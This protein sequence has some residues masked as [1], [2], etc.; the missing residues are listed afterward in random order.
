MPDLIY[1]ILKKNFG[2]DEFRTGQKEIIESVLAGNDNF[3]LMPT[4]SGKS[5]CYQLP[6][7]MLSGLTLV[8]SP[9]IALMKDQVDSL[10]ANGVKAAFINS[11]LPHNEILPVQEEALSGKLKI[12]Y[13]APERMALDN[14]KD[15]LQNL[16]ISLIAVDEAHCISEWGHD[17]R[18]DY[19]NLKMLKNI[20]RKAPIIALTATAT[21]KVRLDI[22]K[23]L[24][25]SQA[26]I[27]ISGF[28]RPNLN[29]R[30]I[31]KKNAFD[32]LLSL[33]K[34]Y[35]NKAVIIYCFSRKETE[36]LAMDLK[37]TGFKA[38]AY[39][40][41]MVA[42]ERK[43]TQELFIRDEFNII[44]ATIAFGM[45]IDK[46][47]VRLVVHY[48]FPKS[49]EGYYQEI[50][51]AGRDGLKSDCVMF[52]T[53]ADARKHE[54][55]LNDIADETIRKQTENKLIEV[56]KFAELKSCRRKHILNYFGENYKEANCHGCDN[57]NTEKVTLDAT[58]VAQKILSAI[59]RTGNRF[60]ANHIINILKGK[61]NEKIINYGH[62]KLSVYDIVKDYSVDELKEIINLI[63]N[64]G[65][66][67]KT[68]D[69]Y[70]VLKVT[71]AGLKFISQKEKLELSLPSKEDIDEEQESIN[72]LTYDKTLFEKLRYLR[73]QI[74]DK[75]NVP[76]FVIFSDASLQEMAFYFPIDKENFSM[77]TGVGARKLESFGNDFLKIIIAYVK[78]NNLSSKKIYKSRSGKI[79]LPREERSVN[80]DTF[81]ITNE[82]INR[83][84]SIDDMAKARGLAIS[85]IISHIEQLIN[86]GEK[87]D[88]E[89]LKPSPEVYEKIKNAFKQYGEEKLRPVFEY[90]REQYSYEIIRLVRAI[91]NAEL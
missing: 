14:F 6:A 52:Y 69:Q 37:N 84:L 80:G 9:L 34:N 28:N 82:L 72:E 77:I 49:I 31:K 66:I 20:F 32:K 8:I 40:A 53:Y 59:L 51:R 38:Q 81:S 45:G 23:E 30:I 55:F 64:A 91:M 16:K 89:Y 17:F 41:G 26:K 50:G 87:I 74:A 2:Y 13:V 5:L 21:E 48:T 63:I 70:S 75:L 42:N 60:G 11:S 19:R 68:N 47:D 29:L 43:K 58:I 22:L 24:S 27:F 71:Q 7:L 33:L 76:P 86:S 44:V 65:L 10:K 3:V 25:I 78:K 56:M 85:T 73:K 36:A 54:Y 83:Q 4:G 88:I 1:S 57:C 12:L 90:L 79:R 15:F 46:P 18:P 61:K 62:D 67:I 35:E 39:H